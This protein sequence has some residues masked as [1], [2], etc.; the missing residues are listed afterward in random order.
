MLKN[1]FLTQK[2][3]EV[4]EAHKKG[5]AIKKYH[6]LTGG[7]YIRDLVYGANDGIVTTF[8]VVA[9]VAGANLSSNIVLILGFANLFADGLA[10]AIG[11]YLGTKSEQEYIEKERKTEE[12]EIEHVPDCEQKEIKNI[13]RKKGFKG[14]SLIQIVDLVTSNKKLWIDTMMINELGILPNDD[15]SPVKNALA[16]FFSFTFAGLFPLLPYIF[17]FS[18]SFNISIIFTGLSLFTVGALRTFITKKHWLI[19]GLEMLF[20][21]AIAAI[22]AFATGYFIDQKLI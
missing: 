15:T 10:M 14:K 2:I 1:Q 6:A 4:K 11:N 8:A 7:S 9:G 12:W 13:Y 22:V 18:N 17:L 19:A 20:V 3:K 21:G 16:T 5:Y